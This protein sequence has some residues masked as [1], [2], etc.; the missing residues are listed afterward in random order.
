MSGFEGGPAADEGRQRRDSEPSVLKGGSV[1][2]TGRL[3]VAVLGWAGTLVVARQLSPTGWGGYSLVFSLIGLVGVLSDLRVSRQ[4]LADIF[5]A[6][7][8][9]G[10]VVG[11]YLAMRALTGVVAYAIAMAVV[12]LGDFPD[13]VV[14]AMAAAGLI[15]VLVAPSSSL[16]VVLG[17]RSW[18]STQALASVIGQ[19]VQLGLILAVAA[20]RWGSIVRFAVPAVVCEVIVL[21]WKLRH[22][23]RAMPV[24]MR[25]DLPRWKA[26]SRESAAVVVGGAIATVYFRVDSVILSQLDTLRAVG[27]YGIG[28]KFSDLAGFVA[29][30]V[31][32]PALTLMVKSW[33]D[34]LAAFSRAFHQAF[35]I[36]VTA[37]VGLSVGFV[38]FASPLIETLYGPRYTPAVGAARGLVAGQAINYFTTLCLFA[39]LA[40][41]RTRR[42]VV[43]ATVGLV[44]NV[45]L[46]LVLIPAASYDGAAVAT[47]VTEVLVL[48]ILGAATV[49][50]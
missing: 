27:L 48:A 23:R 18:W 37:A 36:L 33:P 14:R 47:V 41:G 38:V 30:A 26:W 20:G 9:A 5:E 8:D 4:V 45:V 28:Y 19:V 1:L 44:V 13:E 43:A 10:P 34:D 22:V 7:E 15:L 6:G 2:L 29:V 16:D 17:A 32:T 50:L 25:V 21:W 49:T 3:V 39:L 11:S 31:C 35:V 12:L 42:Y 40:V 46:N 24:R